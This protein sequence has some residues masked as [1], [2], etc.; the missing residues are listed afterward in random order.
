MFRTLGYVAFNTNPNGLG[1]ADGCQV[2]PLVYNGNK[3]IC[4]MIYSG[5]FYVV[6]CGSFVNITWTPNAPMP[7]DV[8]ININ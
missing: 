8:T 1:Y 6:S 5:S 4:N 7:G 3:N 2:G